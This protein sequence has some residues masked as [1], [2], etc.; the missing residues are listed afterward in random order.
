M[1]RRIRDLD[2]HF[3][4]AGPE[5]APVLL[6]LHS[7][8]TG[9]QVWDAPAAALAGR[10]RVLRP[11]LRG[12]GLTSVPPGPYRIEQMA[13]DVLALLDDLRIGAAHVA[14][15]SIGGLV[16]Q[17]MAAQAPERVTSLVLCDTALAIPPVELWHQRAALARREGM[18]PLVEPVCARWVTPGFQGTPEAAGL[19]AM[20]RRTAPEGYAGAAE[21]IAACDLSGVTPGIRCPALVLVG[22]EDQATPVAAA[23]A[24]RDAIPGARLVVLPGLAHLPLAERPEAVL[25]PMRDFLEAAA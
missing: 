20:L 15:L 14:G 19:R 9:L 7:L 24:L 2:M 6:M 13:A 17:T 3:Q 4:V 8:G 21:A 23:E 18:E 10:F 25:A 22:E 11:D 16:A 5:E 12:H 1:F